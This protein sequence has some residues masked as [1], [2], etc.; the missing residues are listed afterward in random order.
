MIGASF[1]LFLKNAPLIRLGDLLVTDLIATSL[2]IGLGAGAFFAVNW[3]WATDLAAY[4]QVGRYLGISNLATAGAGVLANIG[5]PLIDWGNA[6][7]FGLGY[8]IVLIL[9]GV[10]LAIAVLLLPRV[11]ETRGL[12][13]PASGVA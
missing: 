3:A 2:F 4:D 7:S 1:L 12:R 13:A 10:W 9:G 11:P 8:N 6:Q 5:G